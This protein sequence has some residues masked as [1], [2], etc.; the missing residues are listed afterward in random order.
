MK[1]Y[2]SGAVSANKNYLAQFGEAESALRKCGYEVVNP[3]TAEEEHTWEEWMRRDLRLLLDCEGIA[4]VETGMNTFSPGV[5]LEL[6]VGR[7]LSMDV[8]RVDAW[9]KTA[10]GRL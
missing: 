4:L 1:L 10:E 7:A 6:H 5:K 3:A 9:I 2:L 8:Y